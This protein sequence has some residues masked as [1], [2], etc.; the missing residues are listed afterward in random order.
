MNPKRMLLVAALAAAGFLAAAEIPA[1]PAGR[2]SGIASSGPRHSTA[3]PASRG[4]FRPSHPGGHRPGPGTHW[5]RSH[6]GHSNWGWGLG[7]AIGV[8]WALGW[9]DPFWGG[10]TYYAPYAPYA[11][12][13]AY[14]GYS[15]GYACAQDEDCWRE[16]L[17]GSEP[18]PPTTEV[19][20]AAPG[21]EGGPTQRPLHLNYCDSARAWFPHVRT[22]PG[23]WRLVTPDY[24]AAR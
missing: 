2:N 5:N 13:P 18:A 1:A 21:E 19:A 7:L 8:P 12:G 20:P 6:H 17:A 24:G 15:E 10:P 3:A 22:C 16:R 14:R 11:Y 23:G 4:D 9:Y